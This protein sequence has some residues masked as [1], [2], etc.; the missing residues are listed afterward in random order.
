MA[1]VHQSH[2]SHPSPGVALP[3][4]SDDEGSTTPK[5]RA[6]SKPK[7]SNSTKRGSGV[8]Q[9]PA[10]LVTTAAGTIE[11]QGSQASTSG[12][13]GQSLKHELLEPNYELIHSLASALSKH[14]MR[15]NL[16]AEKSR[17]FM[18][19]CV[20]EIIHICDVCIKKEAK[21]K[22]AEGRVKTV[23]A[24]LEG[25]T[26][27]DNGS[28]SI[29]GINTNTCNVKEEPVVVAPGDAPLLGHKFIRVSEEI[30]AMSII[31]SLWEVHSQSLFRLHLS[32][33]GQVF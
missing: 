32:R 30:S 29:P 26:A 14:L 1:S 2:P 5:P 20:K 25:T 31:H 8:R 7:C 28:N 19:K 16:T 3:T 24:R 22:E 18:V 4:Y 27:L 33:R 23:S 21:R 17:D 13:H 12:S 10:A 6:S 9:K 11:G 15:K